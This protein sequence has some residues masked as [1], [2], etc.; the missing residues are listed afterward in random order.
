MTETERGKDV[1]QMESSNFYERATIQLWT[2]SQ[3]AVVRCRANAVALDLQRVDAVG[4][5]R[6]PYQARDMRACN[7]LRRMRY[8]GVGQHESRQDSARKFGR[9]L[10]RL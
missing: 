8:C 5:S 2:R 6:L 3:A 1:A 4:Q 7:T 10:L 9:R